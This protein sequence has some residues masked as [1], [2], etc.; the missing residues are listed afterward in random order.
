MGPAA[1]SALRRSLF[2]GFHRSQVNLQEISKEFHSLRQLASTFLDALVR[3]TG[4][5]M[6]CRRAATSVTKRLSGHRI[7]MG[8]ASMPSRGGGQMNPVVAAPVSLFTFPFSSDR[9]RPWWRRLIQSLDRLGRALA[10]ERRRRAL[11]GLFPL[12][13]GCSPRGF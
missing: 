4:M 3:P 13:C 6:Q 5:S 2:A 7:D 1:Q 10:A 12:A 8:S 9:R 11:G